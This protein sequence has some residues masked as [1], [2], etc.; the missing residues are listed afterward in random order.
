MAVNQKTA[1]AAA[2]A[3]AAAAAAA[4]EVAVSAPVQ[5]KLELSRIAR[6]VFGGQVYLKEEQY[7]F[8][9]KDARYL[10]SL[11]DPAGMPVF[12]LARTRKKMVAV[13]DDSAV[14][15]QNARPQKVDRV[16]VDLQDWKFGQE[17]KPVG[18]IEIP[19][20]DPEMAQRLAQI[21]GPGEF[22][23]AGGQS[24]G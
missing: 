19:D 11:D 20:E 1:D 18:K 10:L 23:S 5:I 7:V 17:I 22:D 12:R 13:D 4:P 9:E 3:P 16:K 15:V 2:P 8:S 14:V 6:Y 24:I 21:D